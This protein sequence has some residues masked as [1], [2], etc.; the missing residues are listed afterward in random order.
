MPA[1]STEASFA[2]NERGAG[3]GETVALMVAVVA[4]VRLALRLE[5]IA[6][7]LPLPLLMRLPEAPPAVRGAFRL[8]AA[9]RLVLDLRC[10]LDLAPPLAAIPADHHLLLPRL[11]GEEAAVFLVDRVETITSGV[12][13]SCPEPGLN[14]CIAGQATIAGEVMPLITMDRLLTAAERDRIAGLARR[15]SAR[16]ELLGLADEA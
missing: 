10:L 3:G 4:E 8:G 16:A 1:S 13:G 11:Q 14:G 15:C 5:E 2:M 6:E 7:I 9:I 12:V